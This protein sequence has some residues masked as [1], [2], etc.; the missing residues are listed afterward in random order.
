MS[1][2]ITQ[3]L[4]QV[5]MRFENASEAL[6]TRLRAVM[7]A[8]TE[9]V[10]FYARAR[11]NE[12]FRNPQ[13]MMQSIESSVS[14]GSD[15]LEGTVTASG[16]PYLRIHEFGGVTR[17]HDIYPK[18]ARALHFFGDTAAAFRSGATAGTDE[19]FAKHVFHPGSV[20]PERSYLRY[21]LAQRRS[22]I[23]GA[24]LAAAAEVAG[25]R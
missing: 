13:K 18:S 11:I 24:F 4:T 17:P 23:R 16:L 9:Q 19:V 20:M 25:G 8:E 15:F 3:G 21:A 7:Q 2:V 14:E 5:L 12:L 10:A 1:D 6:R 22:A